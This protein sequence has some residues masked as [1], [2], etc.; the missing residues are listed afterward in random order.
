MNTVERAEEASPD[1]SQQGILASYTALIDTLKVRYAYTELR[2]LDWEQ[3]RQTYL[4]EVQ[5]ADAAG[6][7]GAYYVTLNNL[8]L[9]LRDV[10]VSAQ[11][12]TNAAATA[13]HLQSLKQTMAPSPT[14]SGPPWSGPASAM[15]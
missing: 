8:A 2:K 11:M 4:S 12:G 9:S 5:A 10:H 3:I 7:F 14:S 6:D 13:A 1:F 15:G